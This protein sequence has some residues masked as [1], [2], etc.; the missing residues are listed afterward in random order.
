VNG[1][2]AISDDSVCGYYTFKQEEFFY[3]GHFTG[4]PVTPG[5]ILLECMGQIGLVCLGIYLLNLHES[6]K[7]FTPLLSHLD[8]DFSGIVSP[9][10]K[11]IVEAEKVYFRNDV[12]KTRMVMK[13]EDGKVIV[14]MTGICTFKDE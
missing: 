11:V 4:K 6:G 1:I 14:T 5:V 13:N 8:S 2:T 3:Q 10:D 12:L 9:G 7:N